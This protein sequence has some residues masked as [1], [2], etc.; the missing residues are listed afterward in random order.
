MT[1]FKTIYG[2][3]H[4]GQPSLFFES[5]ITAWDTF[6]L[7][8]RAAGASEEDVSICVDF[9]EYDDIAD[10]EGYE[11]FTSAMMCDTAVK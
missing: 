6:E 4:S 2:I 7:F 1:S 3:A 9:F 5:R 8:I 11:I 10:A